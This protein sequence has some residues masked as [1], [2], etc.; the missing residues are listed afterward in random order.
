VRATDAPYTMAPWHRGRRSGPTNLDVV[1]RL[2]SRPRPPL[3]DEID[4][5]FGDPSAQ[6]LRM[7][8]W[9]PR[10]PPGPRAADAVPVRCCAERPT[11]TSSRWRGPGLASTRPALGTRAPVFPWL[12]ARGTLLLSSPLGSSLDDLRPASSD[13]CL[14]HTQNDGRDE[15]GAPVATTTPGR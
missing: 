11:R 6:G 10:A 5:R 1:G 9:G 7:A 14:E 13:P 2:P 15:P 12:A 3:I 4:H 8:A